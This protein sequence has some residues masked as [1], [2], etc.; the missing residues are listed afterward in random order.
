MGRKNKQQAIET[1]SPRGFAN[2]FN[3]IYARFAVTD[4]Q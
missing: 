1:D 2:E 4:Q 3:R